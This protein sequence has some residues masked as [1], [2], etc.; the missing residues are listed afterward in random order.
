MRDIGSRIQ[1]MR[2]QRYRPP[3]GSWRSLRWLPLAAALW[4]VY[5]AFFSEHSLFRI[6]RV[7]DQNRR[8]RVELGQTEREIAELEASLK[9]PRRRR[10]FDE[11]KLR[12]EGGLVRPGEIIYR[13]QADTTR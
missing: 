5:A 11:R 9:D 4:L 2:L 13:I 12:E 10:E 1:R 8:A 3:R 6:W 7:H